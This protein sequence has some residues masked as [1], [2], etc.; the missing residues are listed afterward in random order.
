MLEL[1]GIRPGYAGVPVLRDTS[2]TVPDGKVVALLGPNGAGKTTL[3]RVGVGADRARPPARSA[4]TGRRLT[5]KPADAFA[6]AGICHVPEGRGVFTD[7]DRPREPPAP[8]RA[9]RRGER[10]DRTGRA[11][12]FPSSVERLDQRAGTLS[13]GEQQMPRP[14]ARAYVAAPD[15]VLLDEV[16]MGLAP[17][18]VDEIFDFFGARRDRAR[19]CSWWSST[20]PGPSRS[21][22]TS[23]SSTTAGS[24]GP[25]SPPA[26]TPTS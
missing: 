1:D 19:R 6:G 8:G 11:R 16:S 17:L 21:P 18:V 26:S 14:V 2:I 4:S 13:G 22:T 9:A 12:P 15:V 3:L 5:G 10:G 25:A 20:S 24:C 23:T 7:A